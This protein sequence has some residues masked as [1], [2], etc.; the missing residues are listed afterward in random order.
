MKK[1]KSTKRTEAIGNVSATV[2][3]IKGRTQRT[4][5]V[6]WKSSFRQAPQVNRLP[7]ETIDKGEWWEINSSSSELV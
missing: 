4:N 6:G 1:K 5:E 3:T 7:T 2:L